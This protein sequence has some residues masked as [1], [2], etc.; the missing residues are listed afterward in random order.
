MKYFNI[1]GTLSHELLDRF[2]SFYNHYGDEKKTIVLNSGGG[3]SYV[4]DIILHM[5]NED[6]DNVKLICSGCQSAAFDIFYLAK[7]ERF[8]TDF[9]IGMYHRKFVDNIT[10][11]N[12]GNL[13]HPYSQVRA[14]N[15][16]T[17]I[18][19]PITGFMTKKELADYNKG[20]DVFFLFDRMRRIFPQA[21]IIG[22]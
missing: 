19:K 17:G 20:L 6:A 11:D 5:I 3:Q 22:A 18:N 4:A 7:C 13:G 2:M 16:K 15:L 8:M 10:I 9:C 12:G 14:D 1:E 21:K